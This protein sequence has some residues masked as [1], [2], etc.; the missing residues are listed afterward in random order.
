MSTVARRD[1]P[2]AADTQRASVAFEDIRITRVI[3]EEVT[4]PT[5]DGTPGSALY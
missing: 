3:V 2:A 1:R 4:A 5:N